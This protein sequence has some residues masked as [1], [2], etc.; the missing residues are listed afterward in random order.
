MRNVTEYESKAVHDVDVNND[1]P[2]HIRVLV[3]VVKESKMT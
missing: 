2:Y 1:H 3:Y